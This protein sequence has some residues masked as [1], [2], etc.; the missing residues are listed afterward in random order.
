MTKL[1][2]D[3]LDY[4][5][6][7]ADDVPHSGI[8]QELLAHIGAITAERDAADARARAARAEAL[9]EAAR[10]VDRIIIS[11]PEDEEED[12]DDYRDT[13]IARAIRALAKVAP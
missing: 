2:D 7:A 13:M 9:E 12:H 6:A 3:R 1:T 10:L 4:L 8:V 5:R 11:G